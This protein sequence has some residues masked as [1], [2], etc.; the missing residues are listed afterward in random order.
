MDTLSRVS[1]NNYVGGGVVAPALMRSL[2]TWPPVPPGDRNTFL[3][4]NGIFE[5]VGTRTG[6]SNGGPS[7]GS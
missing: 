5:A 2:V 6:D 7:E 4:L 3:L 1:E